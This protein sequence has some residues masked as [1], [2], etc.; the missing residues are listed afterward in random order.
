MKRKSGRTTGVDA[1]GSMGT[2]S[3]TE[4]SR[5]CATSWRKRHQLFVMCQRVIAV[6][7]L[8]CVLLAPSRS[9]SRPTPNHGDRAVLELLASGKRTDAIARAREQVLEILQ[10]ENACTAWFQET[11]SDPAEVFQSLHF[12]LEQKGPSFVYTM[13]DSEHRQLFK[14]PWAA[15]SF[16][17]GGRNSVVEVNVNGSFFNRTSAIIQLEPSGAL[18]RSGSFYKMAIATFPG[19][20]AEAQIT[21][22]L[23]ELGHVVGRLPEDGD[24]W[25]GQSSRNT[26]EV[27]RHCGS[28]TRLA[29]HSGSRSRN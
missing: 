29:A 7:I 6:A 18:P 5:N 3:D 1:G 23:H 14:Q 15:R 10:H 17:N 21:I 19:N 20:T 16:E 8:S 28:E 27:L 22:L 13:Q 26:S 25:D 12:E 24:S 9:Y 11:V 2:D 4:I